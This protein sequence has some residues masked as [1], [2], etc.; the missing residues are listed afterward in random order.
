MVNEFF[1]NGA[2]GELRHTRIIGAQSAITTPILL[3][4]AN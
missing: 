3:L 1:L 2:R 4:P